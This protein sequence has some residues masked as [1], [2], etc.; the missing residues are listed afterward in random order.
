MPQ[1]TLI[2]TL[3]LTLVFA[4][5]A[6]AAGAD[7]GKTYSASTPS[8]GYN[9]RGHK[10]DLAAGRMSLSVAGNGKSVTV[11]FSGEHPIL[12]CVTKE[13]THVT[14]LG[15][16]KLLSNGSFKV[17]VGQRFKPGPG[18]PSIL[19]VVTGT[20]SGRVV[21]GTIHTEA[22]ACSGYTNFTATV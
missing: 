2:A 6:L 3:L 8:W 5:G 10:I 15:K 22:A 20:F 13:T 17:T 18:E 1:R 4:A 12:Y 7:R 14:A 21:H 19:Q 16:G 9:H 11:R